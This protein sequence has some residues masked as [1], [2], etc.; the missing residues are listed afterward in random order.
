V[1]WQR[2]LISVAIVSSVALA[3]GATAQSDGTTDD[4]RCVVVGLNLNQSPIETLRGASVLMTIY[5]MGRL[6]G[7][8]P[9]LDLKGRIADEGRKMSAGDM[10]S[11]TRRCAAELRAKG[12][13]IAEMGKNPTQSP[14]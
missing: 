12:E 9:N 4:V 1:I 5:Y 10:Q 14:F 8:G 13:A 2:G 6:E 7:R 3:S 11:E